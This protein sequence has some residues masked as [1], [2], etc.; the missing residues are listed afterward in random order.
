M[1]QLCL[2]V[3]LFS[4]FASAKAQKD[5]IR[6][7]L[8]LGHAGSVNSAVFSSDGKL[9]LTASDDN[10]A[11][12][13]DAETGK[14]IYTLIGHTEK[15]VSAVLSTDGRKAL[16]CSY[17]R[18]AKIWD[19]YSGKLLYSL[20]GHTKWL[21][22][23]VFSKDGQYALTASEDYTAKIWSV[24]T[25]KLL[26]TLRGHTN[27][28]K[29]VSFSSD[30]KKILTAS[31]D[32]TAKTWETESGKLLHTLRGHTN[33]V[34]S[35]MFSADNLKAVTA[36][37]DGT[38]KI[39][40]I[41]SG[42][43]IQSLIGHGDCVRSAVFSS[44]GKKAI[45]ASWDSTAKIWDVESGKLLHNLYGHT[46]LVTSAV[47]NPDGKKILTISND[48][49]PKL[50]EAETGKLLDTFYGHTSIVQMG[51]FSVEGQR[52][53]T[54][55]MDG[56]AKIWDTE[57][58]KMLLDLRGKADWVKSVVFSPDGKKI[59]TASTD[60]AAKVW[61]VES[62]RLLYSLEHADWVNSAVFIT[63]GT[64][65][66]TASADSTAKLWHAGSGK[67]LCGLRGHTNALSSATFTSDGRKAITASLDS[68][69]R[70]WDAETGELLQI[71]RG[72]SDRLFSAYFSPDGKK[73]LTAS[74]D[75]TAK[76][77]DTETGKLLHNL[78][79]KSSSDFS[80]NNG[81]NCMAFF[82]PK[83]KRIL[84]VCGMN[85]KIWSTKS[86][87]PLHKLN[88]H[89][90]DINSA[91]F[92]DDG[93]KVIT[94]SDDR[95]SIIWSAI[96]G[97]RLKTLSVPWSSGGSHSLAM[98]SRDSKHVLTTSFDNSVK[99]WDTRSGNLL[100]NFI[101]H[102]GSISKADFSP[103]DKVVVT[104]SRDGTII[105]WNTMNGKK[106]IQHF[107]FDTVETLGLVHKGFY[108]CSKRAASKL[109]Y[110][111]GLQTIGFDQLDVK[112][113]R[114]DKVLTELGNAFGNRD[115]A[116]INSY[117]KAWQKRVKKLGVD[118]TSFEEGFSVPEGDFKNR[119]FVPYEQ[120]STDGKLQLKVW[121]MDSTYKLDRYNVWVNEVPV[122]GQ[123]GV[124]IRKDSLNTIER[125]V[126]ITL[127]EGENKIETSVLNINGIESYRVPLY[128]RYTPKQ[129]AK[130]KLYF[131]GIGI[132]KYNQEGHNLQ[133]S[134][135]DIRDLATK[136]KEQ[137]GN[138]IEVDTLLD[139]NVSIQN[140]KALKKHLLQSTVND[141][142]IVA[143]SGHGLLSK[144]YDYYLSTYNVNFNQPEEGGLPYED[145]EWLLDSIPA[146]KKLM[147]IDAC[148]SGEL[149]KEEVVQLNHNNDTLL[150]ENKG[151]KGAYITYTGDN[152]R[153]GLKN[154]FELMQEL[155]ANVNR[156][157]GATVIAA[158]GGTQFAQEHGNL[159][160]G[161]FTYSIL[162]LMQQKKEV[163]VSELKT[164]V[165][166]RVE[167]LTNGNQKPTSRNENIEFDWKV[168]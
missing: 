148:H 149:D 93:K 59:A 91:V 155:F 66:L 97:L 143:F 151:T 2:F 22:S 162:E 72:H 75:K 24:E 108:Q 46:D 6:L 167:E 142:V 71:L 31:W 144:D 117:Y 40:D 16:T 112:Y 14:P 128:V 150:A 70:I 58:G 34:N 109:Y 83:G 129:P 131:V 69:A 159:K 21:T 134:A 62:G 81:W 51:L 77:W 4:C 23:A 124:N 49:F 160:N 53:I 86:G 63:D 101:G 48:N 19:C 103:N 132:D 30:G 10:T 98:F 118:T 3:L 120:T 20:D 67:L 139:E 133:Y 110:I 39:W 35:V 126:T 146:R 168:W 96:G 116:L 105:L 80:F 90:F 15:I 52:I 121:G 61:D 82:S 1:R 130:E 137:Y 88:A 5:S 25:G 79:A 17:D 12:V 166:K 145:L 32:R 28:I 47:F 94:A 37:W 147:L 13:W 73:A 76:I 56:T 65:V 106:I 44:D 89:F 157:T 85:A 154:S 50:W 164:I 153:L 42:N 156:G 26:H 84:T 9:V 136:L 45:T 27:E 161:V 111:R 115:T 102:N 33:G 165:G 140:I 127:S 68:T 125:T 92:S 18:T 55:S 87:I 114:P 141:K 74:K 43:L 60:N 57:T 123:R 119:E 163:K 11:K 36:S 158:S 64:K 107:I 38:A 100:H 7:G 138:D 41:E 135:K 78:R 99:L 8:P 29:S 95:S 152:K 54:A 122:F 104:S 113:N